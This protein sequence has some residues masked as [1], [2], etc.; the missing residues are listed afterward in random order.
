MHAY[1]CLQSFYGSLHYITILSL[2]EKDPCATKECPNGHRCEVFEFTGETFCDP[3]CSL[4]NG[5]CRADQTCEL[6][7]VYCIRAP[8]PPLVK[9]V[10]RGDK[11]Y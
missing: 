2:V 9:C 7:T 3:D 1:A 5:G 6:E 8:C 10:D 11:I 4:N